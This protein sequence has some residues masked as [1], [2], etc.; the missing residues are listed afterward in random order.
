MQAAEA[1]KLVTNMGAVLKGGYYCDARVM[2]MA[3]GQK[4]PSRPGLRR[5][6]GHYHFQKVGEKRNICN[7]LSGIF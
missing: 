2:E 4:I 3:N 5:L 6:Y 1:L 7:D